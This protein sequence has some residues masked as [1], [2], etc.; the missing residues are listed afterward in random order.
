MLYTFALIELYRI[1][2][3]GLGKSTSQL[4]LALIE[5][6]RIETHRTHAGRDARPALIELYRIETRSRSSLRR[7]RG[8]LIEL[9]RIETYRLRCYVAMLD[10]FNRTL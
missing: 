2:T 6:Y 1:E 4:L 5:L 7:S 3:S 10:S 9:Y 8:A